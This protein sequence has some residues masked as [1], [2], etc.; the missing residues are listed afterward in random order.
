MAALALDDLIDKKKEPPPILDL[1][2]SVV[3][4][5]EELEQLLARVPEYKIRPEKVKPEELRIR[6]KDFT[7]K[8]PKSKSAKPSQEFN[9]CNPVPPCMQGVRLDDLCQVEINWKMLTTIRPKSKMDEELFS[10]L[11]ELGKLDILRAQQDTKA[12]PS[13][14]GVKKSKNRAGILETRAQTCT[15]C[16]VEFCSGA[17]CKEF[18]YDSFARVEVDLYEG[19]R[20]GSAPNERRPK[21]KKGKKK[22]KGGRKRSR[23]KSKKKKGGN[24]TD[25]DEKA[26][27]DG[28]AENNL[29]V[30]NLTIQ[31][32]V[33]LNL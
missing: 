23:S 6:D 28:E 31:T 4:S 20:E 30:D 9:Y 1:S 29:T 27:A 18:T 16:C 14:S 13:S 17:S 12:G 33:P 7:F 19:K 32:K 21:K 25:D 10:R 24:K 8:A 11:V 15:E 5:R 26:P 22:G 2:Q 3:S